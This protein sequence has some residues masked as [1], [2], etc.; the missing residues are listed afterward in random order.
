MAT[1]KKTETNEMATMNIYQKLL[2]ARA[3]FLEADVKKTGKNMHLSFKY[4]ELEDIVPT[5]TR[6]FGEVGII[7]VVNFTNDTA[8]MTMVNT[9][10]P[11]ETI[12]FV[13][14]FNQIAPIV[15]NTGK[16]ATNEM[17]ALGS[18]IT[19]MRRYLY[20]IALDICESDGI[21]AN[22]GVPTTTPTPKAPPA[23]PEQRQEVKQEL[24]APADNATSLQ[25]KG[26]KAVLKKLKDAD[27]TKEEM[28]AQIAVQTQGFTVVSKADCEAL[29][30]RI[31][32]MLEGGNE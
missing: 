16:Q 21:D 1:A 26:L 5:A 10:N 19:Y 18:S 32:A 17:M 8:T 24:T 15:S 13:S 3:S 30:Q 12:S 7:P 6:I 14:P 22:A 20:M 27:P 25:I 23:T 4:F 11:E 31:T 29:I 28:I 2:K 9:D